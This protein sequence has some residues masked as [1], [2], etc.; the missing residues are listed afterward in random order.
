MSFRRSPL[1][2][3]ISAKAVLP[4][5]LCSA[6]LN[7]GD[8]IGAAEAFMDHVYVTRNGEEV[9]L[10]HLVERRRREQALFLAPVS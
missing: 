3:I 2:P 7:N 9:L 6:A 10:N 4:G 8:R 5:P 1:S